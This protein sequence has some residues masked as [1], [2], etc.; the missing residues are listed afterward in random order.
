MKVYQIKKNL[1]YFLILIGGPNLFFLFSPSVACQI[2]INIPPIIVNQSN[3]H[4]PDLSKSC[5]LLAAT[6]IEGNIKATEKIKFIGP[7][8]SA[9]YPKIIVSIIAAMIPP[10]KPNK[11]KNQNSDL[12]AL[13]ENIA[14]LLKQVFIDV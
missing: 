14:Y 10:S 8:T 2:I 7:F 12:D 5:S 3:C 11:T 6:E 9:E 13:P 4:Q 1:Y